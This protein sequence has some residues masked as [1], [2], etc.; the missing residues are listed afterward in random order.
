PQSCTATTCSTLTIPVSV[1]TLTSTNCT[2]PRNMPSRLPYSGLRCAVA[3]TISIGNLAASCFRL[4]ETGSAP[5]S[6]AFTCASNCCFALYAAFRTA[7]VIEVVVMLPPDGGPGGDT[8][9]PIVT[10]TSLGWIPSS[11]ATTWAI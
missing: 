4:N 10:G 1:S 8:V 7:G 5:L 2:Q 9:S 3:L 11:S 6:G